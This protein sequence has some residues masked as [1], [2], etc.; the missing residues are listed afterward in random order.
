MTRTAD[1]HD[2]RGS[3]AT[4]M[5]FIVLICATLT[6]FV[7]EVGTR[8]TVANRA[9]TVAAEAARAASIALGVTTTPDGIIRAE[10]AARSYLATA[11]VTGTVTVSDGSTV[12]VTVTAT[13]LTPLLGIDVSATR[14]HSAQLE[15][16][17][18][19][20]EGVS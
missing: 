8:L 20:P 2:D 17:R 11:G 16:G 5:C 9:D 10:A 18:T 6:G 12:Q 7:V 3:V 14:T 19:A 13:E 15:V 1:V 4:L